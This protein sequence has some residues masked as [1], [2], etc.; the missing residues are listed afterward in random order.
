M[1]LRNGPF[2]LCA[3]GS[4]FSQGCL[5]FKD[6]GVGATSHRFSCGLHQS[7]LQNEHPFFICHPRY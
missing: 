6:D 4:K 7:Y 2:G 5:Y 3:V 1:E